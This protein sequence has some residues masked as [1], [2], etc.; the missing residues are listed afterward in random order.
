MHKFIFSFYFFTHNSHLY[1]TVQK[2]HKQNSQHILILITH[3]FDKT[4]V[5]AMKG[6]LPSDQ[7]TFSLGDQFSSLVYNS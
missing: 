2:S 3:G 1:K 4:V 5:W 7:P 6:I